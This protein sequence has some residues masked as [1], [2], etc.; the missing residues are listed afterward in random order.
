MQPLRQSTALVTRYHFRHELTSIVCTLPFPDPS[1]PER[2]KL[3][4]LSFYI[5]DS[6]GMAGQYHHRYPER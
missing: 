3:M 6:A 4:S 2:V 1:L 5:R